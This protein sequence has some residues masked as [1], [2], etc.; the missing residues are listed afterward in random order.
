MNPWRRFFIASTI[1]ALVAGCGGNPPVRSEQEEEAIRLNQRGQQAFKNGDYKTAIAEYEKALAIHRSRDHANGVA[2][3]LM[4]LALAQRRVGNDAASQE[5]LDP[6]FTAVLPFSTAHRAEAAYRRASFY[7]DDGNAAEARHWTE[8]ALSYCDGCV[9]VGRAY[10]LLARIFLSAN[11]GES[12]NHARRAL[13]LN[14]DAGDKNEE[15]NSLRLIA[16]AAL[17]TGDFQAA[18]Q[19]YEDALRLDKEA[20]SASKIALDLMGLSN[21]LARQG[22]TAAASEY[23]RRAHSAAQGAGETGI[24]EAAALEMKRLKP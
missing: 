9:A 3:E 18:Q 6:I 14:R 2:V 17:A 10:N 24:M 23:F 12:V 19:S 22:K 4:N 7:L 1:L 16:D 15:A 5:A 13:A 21:S 8:K 11:P 20:G